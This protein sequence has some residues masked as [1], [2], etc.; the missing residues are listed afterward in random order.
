MK[1][2]LRLLI[3]N[4]LLLVLRIASAAPAKEIELDFS[5]PNTSVV[6]SVEIAQ[7]RNSSLGSFRG[8]RTVPIPTPTPENSRQLARPPTAGAM[9]LQPPP[10]AIANIALDF[11]V[12]DIP[13]VPSVAM[14]R[15]NRSS[16]PTTVPPLPPTP[17]PLP[18]KQRPATASL[19]KAKAAQSSFAKWA[20]NLKAAPKSGEIVGG[21]LVTSPYGI[22]IH[23]ITGL[24]QFHRGVDLATPD[25][26]AVYAIGTPGTKTALKCWIDIKGGGLVASMRT[27][28]LP[29]LQFDALHL[30]WCK[31]KTNAS[32]LKVAPGDIIAGTGNTGT[33]TGPHLHFQVRDLKGGKKI[34]PA[35]GFI[36]W[37]LTGKEPNQN[38][39]I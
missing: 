5:A 33:S 38:V 26:T 7:E 22:R 30:S 37:V 23:P 25:N 20:P 29:N 12:S 4:S 8:N 19:V 36:S 39:Q 28:S 10:K 27:P 9:Q 3:G 34:P 15:T 6:E 2:Y 17:P 35:K 21:Y 16:A 32:W 18:A 14:A 11:S 13:T 1:N 24:L 31:A